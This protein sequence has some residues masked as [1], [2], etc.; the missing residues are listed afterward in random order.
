MNAPWLPKPPVAQVFLACCEQL[1]LERSDQH[2]SIL[3]ELLDEF[4]CP[5]QLELVALE[6][7]SE[8]RAVHE[9]VAELQRWKSHR[10]S[11]TGSASCVEPK[12]LLLIPQ[13]R[14]DDNLC[15][16]P[17]QKFP[18]FLTSALTFS[19]FFFLF[20]PVFSNFSQQIGVFWLLLVTLLTLV[21][22]PLYYLSLFIYYLFMR[23]F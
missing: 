9:R 15:V 14:G 13:L 18:T 6:A 19:V 8:V 4:I 17:L 2:I 20:P 7:L 3:D 21:T 10:A 16:S 5:L 11:V 22:P 1:T 23:H 12:F